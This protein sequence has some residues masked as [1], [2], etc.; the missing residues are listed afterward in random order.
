MDRTIVLE[1]VNAI[2]VRRVYDAV[3]FDNPCIPH[4]GQ[5]KTGIGFKA[6]RLLPAYSLSKHK[7]ETD[8]SRLTE[9]G[10]RFAESVNGSHFD[11]ELAIHDYLSNTVLY[12]KEYPCD[13]SMNG[14]L[15]YHRGACEGISKA[16]LYLLRRCDVDAGI[17]SGVTTSGERH[18]WNMVYI[19]G[20][21]YHL[22]IT[23]DL[24]SRNGIPRHDYFN[25]NDRFMGRAR[26]WTD[27]YPSRTMNA[28]YYSKKGTVVYNTDDLGK[29]IEGFISRRLKSIEFRI[30]DALK[31]SIDGNAVEKSIRNAL[32]ICGERFS[33]SYC[34]STGCCAFNVD[35]S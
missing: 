31:D 17:L 23:W 6:I 24:G 28:N 29:I 1:G 30:S 2:D 21:C 7:H 3:R 5:M 10:D 19:D 9:I 27:A 26:S 8:I 35:Y 33:G 32:E 14:P 34:Q 13:F 15:L 18:A 12:S 25:I 22:D 20:G 16:A 11:R 4:I